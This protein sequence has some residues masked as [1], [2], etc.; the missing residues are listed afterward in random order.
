MMQ[1]KE[2]MSE[3]LVLLEKANERELKTVRAYV[4]SILKK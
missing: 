3:V 4:R 1:K 2:L